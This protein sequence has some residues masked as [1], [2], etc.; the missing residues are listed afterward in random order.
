MVKENKILM[1]GGHA[2]A[3]AYALVSSLRKNK[4]Y[5]FD[6]YFI[7]AKTA[8][9]AT[10]NKT[11]EEE[12]LPQLG[13]KFIAINAG[14]L[15]RKFTMHTLPSIL[16]I[17]IGFIQS[18]W[19]V[20]RIKPNVVMSFGGFASY[21]VVLAAWLN[22]IPVVIHEQTAVY[23]RAN[24]FSERL[25][26]KIAISR[27]S[28]ASYFDLKKLQITGNPVSPEIFNIK[29][30]NRLPVK[31]TLFVTGG[32]RGSETINEV[33]VKILPKLVKNYNIIHQ[34]GVANEHKYTSKIGYEAIGRINPNIWAKYIDK[35]DIIISRSGANIVSEI[36]IAKRPSILIP[37]PWSYMD[38]QSQNAKYA[39]KSGGVEIV[40]QK[41]LT[42]QTLFETIV[43]VTKNW[44]S[45][46]KKMQEFKSEDLYA[47]DKLS[48]LII[49]L[50]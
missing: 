22:N 8:T 5:K 45:M 48:N 32:S 13:V 3:T 33:F 26:T 35:A 20:G 11:L 44:A 18:L 42:P 30:K 28:S 34:V 6:I 21:P 36:L 17:P 24:K 49:D 14:R 15:Q 37:I 9:E 23:G 38:E 12:A 43:R 27:Q 50:L 39:L 4:N 7:G 16:K 31:P 2:G 47:S 46:N 10:Y 29:S 40:N 1:T 41:D 25:A 19:Y